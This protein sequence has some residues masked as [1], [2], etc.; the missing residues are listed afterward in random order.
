LAV[1]KSQISCSDAKKVWV[2]PRRLPR[3]VG[4][5]TAPGP[6]D[7]KAEIFECN[8]NQA[9][10]HENYSQF[11]LFTLLCQFFDRFFYVLACH[12]AREV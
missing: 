6:Y 9:T 11:D 5:K 8:N 4:G 2:E 3:L 12:Y 1:T 7:I 10:R